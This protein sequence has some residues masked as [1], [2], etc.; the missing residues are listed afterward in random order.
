MSDI[1]GEQMEEI[2]THIVY[3]LLENKYPRLETDYVILS[4]D[5]YA[6]LATHRSAVVKALEIIGRRYDNEYGVITEKMEASLTG[7]DEFLKLPD[8]DY[9]NTKPRI[10]RG[11]SMP[12]S[13]PYWYAFLETPSGN[14]YV[15]RDFVEFNEILFPNRQDVDVYRW[16]DDFSD[17]FD[18][19]KEWW[20]TGLWSIYDK[21]TG[22][23]VIIGASTTD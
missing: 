22:I 6:G 14:P 12:D 2:R 15:T 19:G 23:L 4:A 13:I 10:N 3:E 1:Y 5:E 9:Y 18:A 11:W 8:D 7:I 20:G 16:N 17:Y 21:T